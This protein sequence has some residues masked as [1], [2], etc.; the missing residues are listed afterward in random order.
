MDQIAHIGLLKMDY[1]GLS[2]LTILQRA[3]DLIREQRGDEIDLW[4]LPDGDTL[5]MEA[6]GRGE[7]FG[8][9]QLESGGMRRYIQDLK[10]N[11]IADLCAMVALYRPGPMQHIPRFIDGK[12]GKIAVTYPH[13]DL[14]SILDETHGVIVYQDQVMLIARKFAGYTLG[15]ADVMRKAM[16]KKKKDLMEAERDRFVSGAVANGYA[17]ETA[18][19]VFELITPFAGYALNKAHA[20]SATVSRDHGGR[21]TWAGSGQRPYAHGSLGRRN[22][23]SEGHGDG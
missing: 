7:T 8:V 11:S 23:D 1:L 14:A 2:N 9:F 17:R 5:A 19:E 13:P 6:L 22:S 21:R 20:G 12:H 10:P 18:E 15:Q 3:I 4:A 16:G